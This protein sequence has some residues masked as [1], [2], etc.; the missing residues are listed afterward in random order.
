M[1]S[2]CLPLIIFHS[3]FSV[4]EFFPDPVP[5][6]ANLLY[7]AH[8]GLNRRPFGETVDPSAY[9]SLPG[10]EA[11]L[12][13]LRY[14]LE[15]GQGPV[16]LHGPA[17]SGKTLVARLLAQML[18]GPATHLTFPALPAAEFLAYLADELGAAPVGTAGSVDT[19]MASSLRRLRRHLGESVAR[20]ERPVLVVDEA[21]LIDDP[22]TFEVLRSLLNF[23]TLG[24]A[25]LNLVLVGDTEILLRL[26]PGLADRLTAQALLG[27]LSEVETGT[28]L[29]GR[30]AAA[31]ASASAPLFD[32]AAIATLHR[33]AEGL[34]R[35]LNRLADLAL[36]VSYAEGLPRPDAR[37]VA[38]ATRELD[39]EGLAA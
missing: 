36:L 12:R 17:G 18:A 7:E 2:L 32:S 10:R 27:A 15:H 6:R 14:G 1:S 3:I 11:V 16:L 26:P 13:R 30:L 29:N 21:H 20:G 28:Y 19:S 23:A 8:F 25:D 33:A 4:D 35:R 24:P 37:A 38:V 5:A 31:G 22:A 9:V 34:P 39:P